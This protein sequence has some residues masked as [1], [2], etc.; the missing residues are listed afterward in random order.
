MTPTISY[1][2]LLSRVTED[3]DRRARAGRMVSKAGTAAAVPQADS[4]GRTA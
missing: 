2:F 1:S 4:L 3:A